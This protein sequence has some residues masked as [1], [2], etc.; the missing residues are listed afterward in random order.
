NLSPPLN[1]DKKWFANHVAYTM[2]KYGM[3]MCV[4]GMA[5]ELKKKKIAVNALWPKTVIQTAAVQN[6]LGGKTVMDKGRTPDILGDAAYKIFQKQSSECTG[7]FFVD[8]DFLREEGM[9]DFGQYSEAS[10]QD[11]MPDFFL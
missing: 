8:E 6:L 9:E 10:P 5:E 3:S 7:N 1:M 11:L 2:S 4:L